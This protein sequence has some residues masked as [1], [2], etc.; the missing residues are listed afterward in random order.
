MKG[1]NV[2]GQAICLNETPKYRRESL[3]PPPLWGD[4]V[5]QSGLP[6]QNCFRFASQLPAE[7]EEELL[8]KVF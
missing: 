7:V 6:K 4:V 5:A 8:Q 1:D 3:D 2:V